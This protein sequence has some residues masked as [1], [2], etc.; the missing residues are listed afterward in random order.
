[1]IVKIT[2]NG[3]EYEVSENETILNICQKL[4]I[5]IPNLCYLKGFS[6]TGACGLCVVEVENLGVV[7]AC[8]TTIKA[9]MNIITDS[10]KVRSI[11]KINIDRLLKRHHINCFNCQK[12]GVC[13]LQEFTFKI[14]GDSEK[15]T[16]D[17]DKLSQICE[18]TSDLYYEEGKCINCMKCVK[19]LNM[20]CNYSLKSIKDLQTIEDIKSDAFLNITDICPTAALSIKSEVPGFICKQTETYDINDVFTAKINILSYDNKIINLNSIDTYIKDQNRLEI[21]HL[22]NREVSKDD[23]QEVMDNLKQRILSNEH[24]LNIFVI[25]DNIDLVSFSYLKILS[26]KFNNVRLCFNDFNIQ[27]RSALGIK[28]SELTSM[29][30]AFFLGNISDIDK[31]R[32]SLNQNKFKETLVLNMENSLKELGDEKF[33]KFRYPYLI[34]YSNIFRKYE[35]AFV[36]EKIESFEK[37]YFNKF[38]VNLNTRIIPQNLSQ[39]LVSEIDSYI[40]ITDI[41]SKFN[42]HDILSL[43]IIGDIDYELKVSE[44]TY[45]ISNSVFKYTGCIHIPSKHYIEDENW[46]IN[47]FRELLKT[48]RAINSNLKS[49]REFLFDLMK[50]IF[51]NNFDSINDEVKRYIKNA[52]FEK[53]DIRYF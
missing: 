42:R 5:F 47:I 33:S 20:A 7:L 25:G 38:G 17:F 10:V 13:K 35:P 1:M 23:Y 4:N 31:L 53:H 40:P 36:W 45:A 51:E 3:K 21:I 43:S 39:M 48:K 52:F 44:D 18:L 2:I 8:K 29:D 28:R 6:P 22:P 9:E 30:F 11:R 32:F 34:V 49:N 26:E 50:N 15:L 16:S 24:E 46:Y 27:N 12:N 41:F 19:F 14:C 37:D